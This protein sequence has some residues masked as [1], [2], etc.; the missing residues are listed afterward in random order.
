MFLTTG[1]VS[2]FGLPKISTHPGSHFEIYIH[3]A[4]RIAGSD[5]ITLSNRHAVTGGVDGIS[6]KL[7]GDQPRQR[8]ALLQ[9]G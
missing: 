6:V 3:A 8:P 1:H 9:Y 2:I 7:P 4:K 5:I